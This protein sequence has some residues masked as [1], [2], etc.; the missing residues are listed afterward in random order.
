MP[1]Q[2][3]WNKSFWKKLDNLAELPKNQIRQIMLEETGKVDGIMLSR[4]PYKYGGLL[5]SHYSIVQDTEH[6]ISASFGYTKNKHLDLN[7][8]SPGY[9]DITN[10]ELA[11]ILLDKPSSSDKML[12]ISDAMY[13]AKNNI[14]TRIN[15]VLKRR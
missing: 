13:D 11:E 6:G 2:G 4:T 15:Q 9:S 12:D 1:R 3:N 7:P 10:P 14:E 8:N 5:F